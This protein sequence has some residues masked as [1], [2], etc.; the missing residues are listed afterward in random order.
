MNTKAMHLNRS[1][2]NAFPQIAGAIIYALRPVPQ[3]N[4]SSAVT[5]SAESTLSI[6]FS[7][8]STVRI[9]SIYQLAI[10]ILLAITLPNSNQIMFLLNVDEI[11][12][13]IA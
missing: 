11:V 2:K 7:A 9:L 6:H 10:V 3:P 13:Q 4:A 8:K 5:V 12:S 1:G